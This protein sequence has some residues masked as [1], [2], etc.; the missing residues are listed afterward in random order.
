MFNST[1]L[2][3]ALL[4]ALSV[5]GYVVKDYVGVLRH[6]HIGSE[7]E[8]SHVIDK[9]SPESFGFTPPSLP[10]DQKRGKS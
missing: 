2:V 6:K 9:K 10:L 8:E 1:K 4:I 5:G 7:V 3:V